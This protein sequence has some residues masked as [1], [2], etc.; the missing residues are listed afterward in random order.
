MAPALHPAPA[1]ARGSRAYIHTITYIEQPPPSKRKRL[2]NGWLRLRAE[3]D[4]A[5]TDTYTTAM[6]IAAAYVGD[7]L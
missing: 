7:A 5:A 1:L 4:D 2:T 3:D 6:Q